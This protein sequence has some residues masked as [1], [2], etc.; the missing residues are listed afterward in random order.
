MSVKIEFKSSDTSNQFY[1]EVMQGIADKTGFHFSKLSLKVTGEKNGFKV[2]VVK[3]PTAKIAVIMNVGRDGYGPTEEIL[4]AAHTAAKDV[5]TIE[6]QGGKI[7]F[8]LKIGTKH[9]NIKMAVNTINALTEFFAGMGFEDAT[10]TEIVPLTTTYT[11]A[12][13][14]SNVRENTF[15]GTVGAIIGS[16]VGIGVIFLIA[17]IGLVAGIGGAVLAI[18]TLFGYETLA[19]K[20][21]KKGIIICVIVMIIA[22]YVA[23]HMVWVAEVEK[24]LSANGTTDP[25][26]VTI[27]LHR[28][29]ALVGATGDFIKDLIVL[30]IFTA[31]GAVPRIKRRLYYVSE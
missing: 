19:K 2:S 30:Y 6:L 9:M 23:D 20:L 21:T 11:N 10:D 24:A 16:V 4:G 13:K 27:F 15:L 1:K 3:H 8:L 14:D 28:I 12:V 5:D 7:V 29:L 17:Q 25:V 18:G 31:L 26:A 22:T